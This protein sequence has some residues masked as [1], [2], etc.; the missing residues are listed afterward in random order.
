MTVLKKL[1]KYFL[2]EHKICW[3]GTRKSQGDMLSQYTQIVHIAIYYNALTNQSP[4]F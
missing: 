2:K 4:A 3:N 1:I